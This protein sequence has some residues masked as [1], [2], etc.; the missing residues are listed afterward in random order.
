MET[1][2]T[3]NDFTGGLVNDIRP[4]L[5]QNNENQQFTNLEIDQAGKVV[6]RKGFTSLWASALGFNSVIATYLWRSYFKRKDH[7]NDDHIILINQV[8]NIFNVYLVY[9]SSSSEFI[10]SFMSLPRIAITDKKVYIVDGRNNNY[11]Y[12]FEINKNGELEK[13]EYNVEQPILRANAFNKISCK[14]SSYED[15]TGLPFGAILQYCFTFEDDEGNESAHSPITTYTAGQFLFKEKIN[16][17]DT[18]YIYWLKSVALN[19][20][21]LPVNTTRIK[22]INVYRRHTLYAGSEEGFTNFYK[23]KRILTDSDKFNDSYAQTEIALEDNDYKIKGDDIA[24]IDNT[25]FVANGIKDVYFSIDGT[26]QAKIIL[27]NPSTKAYINKIIKIY[28]SPTNIL[29]QYLTA[30]VSNIRL[31]DMDKQTPLRVSTDTNEFG[32]LFLFIEIPYLYANSQHTIYFLTDCVLPNQ[33]WNSYEYGKICESDYKGWLETI[34]KPDNLVLDQNCLECSGSSKWPYS[35]LYTKIFPFSIYNVEPGMYCFDTPELGTY[36]ELPHF[37]IN[38]ATISGYDPGFAPA[39]QISDKGYLRFQFKKAITGT[40]PFNIFQFKHTYND[41]NVLTVSIDCKVSGDP[42]NRI[43]YISLSYKLNTG[44]WQEQEVLRLVEDELCKYQF[45]FTWSST[46]SS[47]GVTRLGYC[48]IKKF[49]DGVVTTNSPIALGFGGSPTSELTGSEYKI[50]RYLC[51]LYYSANVYV[52]TPELAYQLLNHICTSGSSYIGSVFIKDEWSNVNIE[53]KRI[54]EDFSQNRGLLYYSN[55]KMQFPPLNYVAL[56][57]EI[58][59]IV[60]APF[61][62]DS[63]SYNSLLIFGK[64]N[65]DRLII[66]KDFD[67]VLLN[68]NVI[69]ELYNYYIKYPNLIEQIGSSLYWVSEQGIVCFNQNGVDNITEGRISFLKSITA[70]DYSFIQ[71]LPDKNQ[72]WFVFSNNYILVYDLKFKVW[73]KFVESNSIIRGFYNG[74]NIFFDRSGNK[75]S[76]PSQTNTPG[77]SKF[78]TKLFKNIFKLRKVLT[79][80]VFGSMGIEYKNADTQGSVSNNYS[81][82]NRYTLPQGIKGDFSITLTNPEIIEDINIIIKE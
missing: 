61:S 64:Q 74:A 10:C 21:A 29:Y 54:D 15:Y 51:G 47:S 79:K 1:K 75:F 67:G 38:N 13:G 81:S 59:R 19:G 37:D 18:D 2:F 63:D 58:L 53:I 9:S 12:Y 7:I 77:E 34:I 71:Y 48:Y 14:R 11:M 25:I 5:L 44:D 46:Y 60:P 78:K 40:N 4:D 22:Y 8:S 62:N 73:Y 31:M 23:V 52:D 65:I 33:T 32:N 57:H 3:L 41:G 80:A 82:T 76:Y 30:N 6:K 66:K 17:T 20:L 16:N 39:N 26:L 43:K 56:R 68:R 35:E 27:D 69:A 49:K 45:L 36:Y 24:F 50:G 42:P 70:N 72:I 55:E 28:I